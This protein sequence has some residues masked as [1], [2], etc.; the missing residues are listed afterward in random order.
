MLGLYYPVYYVYLTKM[1]NQVKNEMRQKLGAITSLAV[2][3]VI[4]FSGT[5]GIATLAGLFP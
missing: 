1:N 3:I 5:I 2:G 4:G